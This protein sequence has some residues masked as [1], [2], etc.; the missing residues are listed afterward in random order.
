MNVGDTV[1]IYKKKN[2]FDKERVPTWTKTT[3]VVEKIENENNQNFY[4]IIYFPKPLE[5][6]EILKV[7]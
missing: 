3:H 7:Y 2:K 4:D 1:R 6:N 5:R